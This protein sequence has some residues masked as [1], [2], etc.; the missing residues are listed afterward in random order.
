MVSTLIGSRADVNSTTGDRVKAQRSTEGRL[1][2]QF[3]TP[4]QARDCARRAANRYWRPP[5]SRPISADLR[6]AQG[7]KQISLSSLPRFYR[8]IEPISRSAKPGLR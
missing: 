7:A 1:F 3:V 4:E 8:S 5:R 6:T 2:V